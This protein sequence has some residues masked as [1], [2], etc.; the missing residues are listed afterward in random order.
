MMHGGNLKKHVKVLRVLS[1]YQQKTLLRFTFSW[2]TILK[3]LQKQNEICRYYQLNRLYSAQ[4][5]YIIFLVC[6]VEPSFFEH[7]DSNPALLFFL[8]LFNAFVLQPCALLCYVLCC[9]LFSLTF[10]LVFRL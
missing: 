1:Q 8:S 6:G 2:K 9:S 7:V 4:I 3:P 5:K 10:L